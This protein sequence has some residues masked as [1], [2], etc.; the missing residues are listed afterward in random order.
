MTE[1][2]STGA[3]QKGFLKIP[4]SLGCFLQKKRAKIK[5]RG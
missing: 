1:I 2:R 5:E 4:V 3:K